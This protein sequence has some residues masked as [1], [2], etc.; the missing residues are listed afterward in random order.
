MTGKIDFRLSAEKDNQKIA[1]EVKSFIGK[2]RIN[3]LEKALGQ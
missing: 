1:V 2:S 3:D